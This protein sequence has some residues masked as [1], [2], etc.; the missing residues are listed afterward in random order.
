MTLSLSMQEYNLYDDLFFNVGLLLLLLFGCPHGMQK[1]LS[2]GLNP[3]HSNDKSHS[4]DDAK[5]LTTRPLGN[6]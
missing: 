1:F 4:S 6:S 3:C 5:P 2:Q